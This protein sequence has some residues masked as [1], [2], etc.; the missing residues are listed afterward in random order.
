L[1]H[2]KLTPQEAEEIL[3]H[4]C[5]GDQRLKGLYKELVENFLRR[6]LGDRGGSVHDWTG[7]MWKIRWWRK[8]DG[9]L[10]Y[11]NDYCY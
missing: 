6:Y 2:I 11:R 1:I 3:D 7:A 9:S 5:H 4:V 8:A 10:V